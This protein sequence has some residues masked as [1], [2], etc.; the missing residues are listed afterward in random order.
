MNKA[1]NLLL[2]SSLFEKRSSCFNKIGQTEL[3]EAEL[4]YFIRSMRLLEIIRRIF[5][6]SNISD[7]DLFD[8]YE[9]NRNAF[10]KYQSLLWSES[11]WKI[12]TINGKPFAACDL[13]PSADRKVAIIGDSSEEPAGVNLTDTYLLQGNAS[14]KNLWLFIGVKGVAQV[15]PN[16]AQ[17]DWVLKAMSS[18]F[19][20]DIGSTDFTDNMNAFI[21]K[22]K[23]KIDEIR[24]YFIGT[25]KFLGKGADGVAFSISRNF[26]LK[27]FRDDAAYNHARQAVERIYRNPEIAK[28]E[29][30]IYDVGILGDFKGYPVYYYIIEK[31]IPVSNMDIEASFGR[32]SDN[33]EMQLISS[34][35]RWRSLRD[36]V[37]DP[38]AHSQLKS[39]IISYAKDIVKN[40]VGYNSPDIVKVQKSLGDKLKSNWLQSLAEEFIVKYLTNRKDL[41]TGNIGLTDYGDFRF[42]DPSYGDNR[43]G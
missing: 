24:K 42:F 11:E 43:S 40:I 19:R 7:K 23:D 30:M 34:K 5:P 38:S 6:D 37:K 29:A 26:V 35:N 14:I 32:I 9:L 21:S 18:I 31:M 33:I 16:I 3:D 39:E 13:F 8:W 1:T 20:L 25:P 41:H 28:T 15:E 2:L 22:N 17:E 36:L 12:A 10:T 4:R 27:I